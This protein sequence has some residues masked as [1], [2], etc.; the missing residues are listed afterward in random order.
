MEKGQTRWDATFL[1]PEDQ[2]KL[3]K[4]LGSEQARKR[5]KIEIK[6]LNYIS[7]V[8]PRSRP[9]DRRQD[10]IWRAVEQLRRRR[11]DGTMPRVNIS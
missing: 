4:Y 11:V 8:R 7:G 2:P 3:R 10:S 6:N 9:R 1:R 5:A